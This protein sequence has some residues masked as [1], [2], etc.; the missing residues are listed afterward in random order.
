MV[1]DQQDRFPKS[2]KGV[3]G[4]LKDAAFAIIAPALSAQ[5][6]TPFLAGASKTMI[7]KIVKWRKQYGK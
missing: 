7:V 1:D 4:C 2:D 3:V 5:A 6:K